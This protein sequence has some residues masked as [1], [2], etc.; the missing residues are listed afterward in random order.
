MAGSE[1]VQSVQRALDILEA[2]ARADYGLR[3]RDIS[4]ESGLKDTTVHNLVRTLCAR[5]YLVRSAD[6]RFEPGPAVEEITRLRYR[7]GLFLRA[8]QE[9]LRLH[10][11]LTEGVLTFAEFAGGDIS[12]RFRIA[13]E[14]PGIVRRPHHQTFSPFGSASGLCLQAFNPGFRDMVSAR[15]SFEESGHSGWASR[16]NFDRALSET[17]RR[18]LAVLH[19]DG[20]Y[21]LAAP[22]GENHTLGLSLKL[23]PADV[24]S[25]CD[26]L[27]RSAL[28]ITAE[29]NGQPMERGTIRRNSVSD[30]GQ[31]VRDG[32]G[33]LPLSALT[34]QTEPGEISP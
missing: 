13:P 23:V 5:G 25:V 28:A 24:D 29:G 9:M 8:E 19:R 1:L 16:E 15:G 12:C 34:E 30:D 20:L 21:R 4:E 18:G 32:R 33:V 31:R 11:L 10:P 27:I 26:R 6:R 7:R 17:V 22:V 3:L 14:L 2:T